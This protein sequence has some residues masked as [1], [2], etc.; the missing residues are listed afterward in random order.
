MDPDEISVS[1]RLGNRSKFRCHVLSFRLFWEVGYILNDESGSQG[2]PGSGATAFPE[3]PP[4]PA[5]SLE[6]GNQATGSPSRTLSWDSVLEGVWET[7]PEPCQEPSS[8][9]VSG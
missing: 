7:S 4:V 8:G 3:V 9:R 2:D 1:G 6:P 5:M